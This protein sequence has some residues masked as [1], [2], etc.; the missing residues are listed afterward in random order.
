MKAIVLLF[1]LLIWCPVQAATY[2]VPLLAVHEVLEPTDIQCLKH[3]ESLHDWR[4]V[5]KKGVWHR[6]SY[7]VTYEVKDVMYTAKSD[8]YPEKMVRV[9]E[10]GS[11]IELDTT[12][13]GHY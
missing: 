4:V 6:R 13:Y 12:M 11:L 3:V 7:L 2:K 10:N 9:D 1:G 8:Y 5:C